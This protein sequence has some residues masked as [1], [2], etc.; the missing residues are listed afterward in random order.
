MARKQARPRRK[1]AASTV[2]AVRRYTT[3]GVD[4]EVR[5]YVTTRHG[6]HGEGP[7]VE[8]TLDGRPIAVEI[9]DGE[10]HCQ[11]A[12]QF[13]SF[14]SV[15]AVVDTLLANEGRTWTLHGA[16]RVGCC[17]PDHQHGGGG[18]SGHQHGHPAAR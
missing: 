11:L 4:V 9:V 13:M 14:P 6:S 2:P 15:D 10:Y 1:V 5:E 3:R 12:N 16:F 17:E 7:R 18:S 8:V